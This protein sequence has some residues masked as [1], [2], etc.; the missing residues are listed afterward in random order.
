[1]RKIL[2]STDKGF[3]LIELMVVVAIIGILS[4]VAVPNFKKYQGKSK[5][6]EAKI[7]LAAVY[8]TETASLSD[9]DAYATCLIDLGYEQN[10]RGYY[11]IG[12]NAAQV[13]LVAARQTAGGGTA[14]CL[15]TAFA[16]QPTVPLKAGGTAPTAIADTSSVVTSNGTAFIAGAAGNVSGTLTDTW[17]I[18]NTKA[19]APLA[20]GI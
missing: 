17:R 8:T 2:L 6:S 7:Q 10:P 15:A 5:Q 16:W 12:F 4:A 18:D 1:M 14:T 3:T 13:T 11:A 9:N 20:S 19:L